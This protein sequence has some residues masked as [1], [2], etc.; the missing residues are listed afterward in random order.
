MKK[1]RASRKSDG[2]FALIMLL[3]FLGL[4][5]IFYIYPVFHNIWLSLTNYS[6]LKLKGYSFIGLDNYKEIFNEGVSGFA[7]M[8]LW[9]FI[10]AFS[11]VCL[12]FIL[13]TVLAVI[14]EKANIT[15]SRIYRGIFLL[16][17]VIPAVITLLMW[18]GL[19]NTNEGFINNVLVS[20]G[21]PRIPWLTDP[22]MARVSSILVMVWFSFP[23]FLIVAQGILK[24]IPKEYY[25]A[26]GIDGASGVQSFF[27]ITVPLTIKAILPTL[28]MAYIMQFNQ[29]GIYMLT[30][31]E[32]ASETLGNPGA[33]DLLITYV[34]NTA[35][36]TYR[37]NLAAAYAVII[38]V[39]IG[40]FAVLSMRAG[41]RIGREA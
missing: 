16:P 8:L 18:R 37:Y 30:G 41:K 25:E 38:F 33:T 34:F 12:S 2:P 15:V 40:L 20:L 22:W 17:W 11:V 4:M 32:P 1:L 28:I 9:T 7:G 5:L 19:L 27:R 13:G 14:L 3:P 39:F 6:G 36:N 10:F 26:A 31:G 24:S 35:F 23:Y 29:F 21:F